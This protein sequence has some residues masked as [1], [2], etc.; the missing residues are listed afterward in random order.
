MTNFDYLK[1]ES[2]FSSFVEVAVN[3]EKILAIDPASCVVS[4]RRAMEFAI[5]WMYS[6]DKSLKKPY[7]ESLV[8]LMSTDDFHDI[9]DDDLW[10]RLD[11]IRKI[12]NRATHNIYKKISRDEAI[13]W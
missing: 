12:G 4:C 5:K 6:I 8:S 1:T 10:K 2:K 3:A 9:V 7:Q 11:L 13:L